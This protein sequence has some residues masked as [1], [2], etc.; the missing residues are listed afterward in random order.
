M[1][2]CLAIDKFPYRCDRLLHHSDAIDV[3]LVWRH[4]V[5]CDIAHVLDLYLQLLLPDQTVRFQLGI[6]KLHVLRCFEIANVFFLCVA[7]PQLSIFIY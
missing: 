4:R 2:H 5:C 6:S 7:C 3:S 1:L